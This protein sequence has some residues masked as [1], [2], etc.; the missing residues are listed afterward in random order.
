MGRPT[1]ATEEQYAWLVTQSDEFKTL[2]GIKKARKGSKENDLTDPIPKFW[3]VFFTRWAQKWPE[4]TLKSFVND[5]QPSTNK[6]EALPDDDML[7]G[8]HAP[9][10]PPTDSNAST[11]TQPPAEAPANDSMSTT[12]DSKCSQQAITKDRKRGRLTVEQVS[13]TIC[14]RKDNEIFTLHNDSA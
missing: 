2:Q 5:S 14:F 10:E 3:P 4:P 6:E 8:T 9:S 7:T 1:W 11:G 12:A 13:W